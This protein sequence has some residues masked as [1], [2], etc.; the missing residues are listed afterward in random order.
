MKRLLL[1]LSLFVK[2]IPAMAQ[3]PLTA[4][5]QATP[6]PPAPQIAADTPPEMI[7]PS[8]TL[9]DRLDRQKG[10]IVPPNVDPGFSVNPG[11]QTGMMPVIPAPGSPGGDQ[12]VVPK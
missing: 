4:A 6:T 5:P 3:N 11:H 2:A 9:S 12:S 7:A 1:L 10:T 8:G